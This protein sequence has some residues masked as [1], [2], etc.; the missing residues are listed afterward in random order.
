[1]GHL[2]HFHDCDGHSLWKENK[3]EYGP[4]V[5]KFVW[6]I[7]SK[8]TICTTVWVNEELKSCVT[9]CRRFANWLINWTKSTLNVLMFISTNGD[10][11]LIHQTRECQTAN[12]TGLKENGTNWQFVYDHKRTKMVYVSV[13]CPNKYIL[14]TNWMGNET[15][16]FSSNYR[17]QI[18][19][20][21][22]QLTAT[23]THTHTL[24]SVNDELDKSTNKMCQ[25]ACCFTTLLHSIAGQIKVP[26]KPNQKK[27]KNIT[28]GKWRMYFVFVFFF[29]TIVLLFTHIVP[30]PKILCD[31]QIGESNCSP[32]T[33]TFSQLGALKE[34]CQH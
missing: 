16:K 25:H 14:W 21:R 24:S 8:D 1:M 5:V 19:T 30:L 20:R 33:Q 7:E 6:R 3:R 2:S 11:D 15:S 12:K 4:I 27:K 9:W 18:G 22:Y 26:T 23:H 32:T 10:S 13:W 34:L 28:I 31:S 17:I 29:F